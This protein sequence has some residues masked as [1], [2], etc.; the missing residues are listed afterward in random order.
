[1]TATP[2][3]GTTNESRP[4]NTPNAMPVLRTCQNES[5]GQ[6][7]D[8]LAHAQ[9]VHDR[10]LGQL[11]RRHRGHGQREHAGPARGAGT[12]LLARVPRPAERAGSG[13]RA[14][15]HQPA[16][17]KPSSTLCRIR[18]ATCSTMIAAMGERSSGPN[19][20]SE[21]PEDPDERAHGVVEE[22]PYPADPD[23]VRQPDPGH[24]D[25]GDDQD[26]V[27]V[28]ERPHPRLDDVDGVVAHQ[29]S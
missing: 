12:R 26:R 20:G 14:P 13:R 21:A 6:D 17:R 22:R 28:H 2:V 9:G 25:P 11:I 19:I 10:R 27:D 18:S 24:D 16:G 5:P 15:Q 8:G 1:M 23:V 4:S 3:I 7:V 29:P